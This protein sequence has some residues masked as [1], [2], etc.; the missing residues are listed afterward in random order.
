MRNSNAIFKVRECR[1]SWLLDLNQGEQDVRNAISAYFND[2]ISIGVA[3]VRVDAAK[4]VWPQ[5]LQA[6]YSATSNVQSSVYRFIFKG[7]SEVIVSYLDIRTQPANVRSAR[8]SG[9][10][11]SHRESIHSQWTSDQFR[12]R[13]HCGGC[14]HA[15][16]QFQVLRRLGTQL[17]Q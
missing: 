5:D 14:G 6:I 1:L 8:S 4:S 9:R 3:G 2:V 15:H 12:L 13:Y 10:R 11:C 16:K 7:I 17:V